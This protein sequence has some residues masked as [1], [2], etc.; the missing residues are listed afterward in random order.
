LRLAHGIILLNGNPLNEWRHGN[1]VAGALRVI[2]RKFV[3]AKAF[4]KAPR[5]SSCPTAADRPKSLFPQ[6][7]NSTIIAVAVPVRAGMGAALPCFLCQL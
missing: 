2:P 5:R 1:S 7:G 6:V 4:E 3:F